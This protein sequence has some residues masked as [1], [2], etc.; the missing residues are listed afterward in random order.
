MRFSV[1]NLAFAYGGRRVFEEITFTLEAG[2]VLCLLGPNGAGKSTLIK[3][4]AGIFVPGAGE[5]R[6]DGASIRTMRRKEFARRV[7]YIPQSAA[8]V[9]PFPVRDIAAMGRTPHKAFFDQPDHRD[10]EMVRA[11]LAELGIE[12]LEYKNCTEL[13]G[14]ERQMVLFAAA[15][16]QEPELLLLDEPTSHLD[17]GNQMRVLKSVKKAL[18]REGHQRHHGDARARAGVSR[19]EPRGDAQGRDDLRLGR[20]LQGDNGEVGERVFRRA[21]EGR[22]HRQGKKYQRLHGADGMTC[23]RQTVPPRRAPF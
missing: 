23:G 12:H 15:M 11:A 8:P 13:S 16:V 9:F 14:G 6:I 20:A 2:E 7:A 21:R 18:R 3:C 19:G 5:I 10:Y 1:E 22:R 4:L 17:F